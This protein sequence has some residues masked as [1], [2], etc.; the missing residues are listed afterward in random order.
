M[1]TLI[2]EAEERTP[3]PW[4]RFRPLFALV[5]VCVEVFASAQSA[6]HRVGDSRNAQNGIPAFAAFRHPDTVETQGP[7]Q[8]QIRQLSGADAI[9]G[10]VKYEVWNSHGSRIRS[11]EV[12][13]YRSTSNPKIWAAALPGQ[14]TGSVVKYYYVIVIRTGTQIRHPSD[15]SARYQ[16]QIVPFRL[17]SLQVQRREMNAGKE[18]EIVLNLETTRSLTGDLVVRLAPQPKD[19][20][21]LRIKLQMESGEGGTAAPHKTARAKLPALSAGQAADFYFDLR[22]SNEDKR[23]VP[24]DAP[25]QVFSVKRSVNDVW[26]VPVS[27]RF[28]LGANIVGSESELALKGGGTWEIGVAAVPKHWGT[29]DGSL[30]NVSRFALSEGK[31]SLTYVGSDRGVIATNENMDIPIVV[32]R[33]E[34]SAWGGTN[35]V[36]TRLGRSMRAGPGA[37]SSLDGSVILQYQQEQLLE[38]RYPQAAFLKIDMSGLTQFSFPSSHGFEVMGLSSASFDN[39]SGCWVFGAFVSENGQD[40]VPAVVRRCDESVSEIRLRAFEV[41]HVLETPV[42]VISVARDP[43]TGDPI[44]ALEYQ[45]SDDVKKPA[46]GVFRLNERS[47]QLETIA[48]SLARSDTEITCVA[49]DWEQDR[50]LIGTF[51]NSAWEV[52]NGISKKLD[53]PQGMPTQI[54]AIGMDAFSGRGILGTSDGAY[55]ISNRDSVRS[56]LEPVKDA[57]PADSMPMD[58]KDSIS[59][60]LFSSYFR[61]LK[62]AQLQRPKGLHVNESW[63]AGISLPEGHVGDAQFTNSSGI[64]AVLYSQG[65]LLADAKVTRVLT[66]SDGLFSTNPFRVLALSSGELWLAYEPLPFGQHSTGAIQS[67]KGGQIAGTFEMPDRG[68]ATISRWMEVKER[69]SIFAATRAGVIEIKNDGSLVSI[70]PNP[71]TSIAQSPASGQIGVVGST[72]ERWDGQKFVSVF[73]EVKHPRRSQGTY[74]PGSPIDIAID[75]QN[76]WYI[77]YSGGIVAILNSKFEFV[78]LLDDDDGIPSTAQRL[79]TLPQIGDILV[80]TNGE[81]VVTIRPPATAR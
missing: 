39:V 46:Y 70:S 36:F 26:C 4:N 21:D 47:G 78:N 45:T 74:S 71:A 62:I 61:G 8:V 76:T 48:S 81:G 18:A 16:F 43:D 30:S 1:A 19:S 9:D 69:K 38:E 75:D 65:L 53:L 51:G 28:V 79:M 12:R 2:T 66:K 31:S 7:Y 40:L 57:L 37:M 20:E 24:A 77:L 27:E 23:T 29:C 44:V 73:Y 14:S 59:E 56:L 11:G 72:V 80:G 34:P 60:V 67:L 63:L 35:S 32:L 58:V 17:S 42:R 50:I 25:G 55:E 5:L 52:R 3:Y 41:E 22:D 54:T 68:T 13:L 10:F 33:P 15:V 64:A 49:T 6:K